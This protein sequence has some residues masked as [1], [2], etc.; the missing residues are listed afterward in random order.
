MPLT[1]FKCPSTASEPGRVNKFE[2]CVN[3][4]QERCLPRSVLNVIVKQYASNPHRGDMISATSLPRCPRKLILTRTQDYVE[5][6][7]N[8]WDAGRGTLIHG[9]L[10]NQNLDGVAT[11]QRL[12]KTVTRGPWAPWVLSGQLDYYSHAEQKIEDYK[13]MDSEAIY[14]LL[15]YGIKD[16][17]VLQLSVYRWLAHGGYIGSPTGEQVFWP[18]ERAQ[19]HSVMMRRVISSGVPFT[20]IV[21]DFKAPN[22]GKVFPYEVKGTRKKVG[23]T[24]GGK[25]K[26]Q[27]TGLI[28]DVQLLSLE[29]T[30]DYVAMRGPN[31]V[32]GFREPDWIPP[33]VM[34]D[35]DLNW[36]CDYCS[37]NDLCE[38][39]EQKRAKEGALPI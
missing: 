5:E 18:V 6:P 33:G 38:A 9:V 15:R 2:F 8:L 21:K 19:I 39:I 37:V 35:A 26:W 32:R 16:D 20:F 22:Y 13:S 34:Y 17:H 12:Y 10:E 30:E 24:S 25:P 36:E 29:E 1:G 31:L 7:G 11:E 14:Q 4:C 3:K 28:P 27:I 23:E